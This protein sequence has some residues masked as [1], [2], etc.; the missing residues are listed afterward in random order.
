MVPEVV[1]KSLADFTRYA[2]DRFGPRLERMV[3]FVS[4]A[5]GEGDLSESDVDVLLVVRELSP[6]ELREIV[7]E[8]ARISAHRGIQV[9]PLA[10]SSAR[11]QEMRRDDLLLYRELERDGV[12]V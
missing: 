8:A 2:R 11:Y 9:A 1:A 12:A 3:L 7:A 6:V 10:L 5:R 4:H